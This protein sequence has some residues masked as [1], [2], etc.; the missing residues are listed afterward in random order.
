M[1]KVIIIISVALNFD[2]RLFFLILDFY[3]HF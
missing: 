3:S 1:K 2:F